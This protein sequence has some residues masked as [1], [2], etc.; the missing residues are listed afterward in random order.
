MKP[1]GTLDTAQKEGGL[2]R[3]NGIA[4]AEAVYIKG[5]IRNPQKIL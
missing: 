4:M 2:Q 5:F 1:H 3:Y